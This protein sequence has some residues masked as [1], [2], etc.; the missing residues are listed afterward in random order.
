MLGRL[1]NVVQRVTGIGGT[2]HPVNPS[3]GKTSPVAAPPGP[4]SELSVASSSPAGITPPGA[5]LGTGVSGSPGA[6]ASP[7]RSMVTRALTLTRQSTPAENNTPGPGLAPASAQGPG[8]APGPGLELGYAFGGPS[9]S[10]AEAAVLL[11]QRRASL[12]DPLAEPFILTP[13]DH[14]MY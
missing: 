7:L 13:F 11:A 1:R 9:I 5:S 4:S 6:N 14:K 3:P 2:P 8:L 12:G 10:M